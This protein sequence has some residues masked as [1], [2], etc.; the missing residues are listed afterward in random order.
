MSKSNDRVLKTWAERIGAE[1]IEGRPSEARNGERVAIAPFVV[2]ETIQNGGGYILT[3]PLE[4]STGYEI[5]TEQ[6]IPLEDIETILKLLGKKL[7]PKK[8]EL[9]AWAE[10]HRLDY[11]PF[12]EERQV[13][14]YVRCGLLRVRRSTVVT[15]RYWIQN[16]AQSLHEPPLTLGQV[17][18]VLRI[19]GYVS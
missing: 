16:N 9:A 17:E 1:Y 13:S 14:E 18:V 7:G 3:R 2:W 4:D 8:T 11:H 5:L 6:P 19:F 15:D 10:K 12:D